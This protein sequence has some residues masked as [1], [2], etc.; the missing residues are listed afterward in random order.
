MAASDDLT[1]LA[2]RAKAAEDRV[3]AARDKARV[4]LEQ[5]VSAAQA[6]AQASAE[7][8]RQLAEANEGKV[9]SW[10]DDTQRSWNQHIAAIREHVEAKKTEHDLDRAERRADVAEDDAA[11]AIDFVFGDRRGRVRGSRRRTGTPGGRRTRGQDRLTSRERSDDRAPAALP[12]ARAC[13]DGSRRRLADT[14]TAAVRGCR[15]RP[16]GVARECTSH[17]CGMARSR[18]AIV[19]SR[20]RY[21]DE[22]HRSHHHR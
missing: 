4:E 2:T 17:D 3:A 11:F 14:T 10:W 1:K 9:S 12:P 19:A 13:A 5:D 16:M 22:R 8:L 7:Q 20:K 21:D 6:D 15:G 18:T